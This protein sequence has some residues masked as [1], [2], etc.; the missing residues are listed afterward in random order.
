MKLWNELSFYFSLPY[1]KSMGRNGDLLN[2]CRRSF[3]GKTCPLKKVFFTPFLFLA[4]QLLQFENATVVC[5]HGAERCSADAMGDNRQFINITQFLSFKWNG[6]FYIRPRSSIYR[7]T[8][9]HNTLESNLKL[10]SG[11]LAFFLNNVKIFLK[12]KITRTSGS[13]KFPIEIFWIIWARNFDIFFN[14]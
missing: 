7:S 12:Q 3:K 4:R 1:K 5:G 10:I 14:F 9:P 8:C 13:W 2:F 6:S 11:F